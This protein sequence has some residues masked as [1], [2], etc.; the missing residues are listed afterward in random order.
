[1]AVDRLR[2]W[3]YERSTSGWK[4]VIICVFVLSIVFCCW[5]IRLGA[6]EGSEL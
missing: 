5:R 6:R 2:I 3:A 4:F 1:M